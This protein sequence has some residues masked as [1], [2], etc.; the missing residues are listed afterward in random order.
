MSQTLEVSTDNPHPSG[1]E[2]VDERESCRSHACGR[3]YPKLCSKN[4]TH[5]FG[6]SGMVRPR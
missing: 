6:V 4:A 3:Q 2:P 5:Q 1:G